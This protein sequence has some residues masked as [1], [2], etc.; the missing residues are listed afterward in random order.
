MPGVD[1]RVRSGAAGMM[2]AGLMSAGLMAAGMMGLGGCGLFGGKDQAPSLISVERDLQLQAYDRALQR[3]DY[4]ENEGRLTEPGRAQAKLLRAEIAIAAGHPQSALEHIEPTFEYPELLAAA[5][6]IQGKA[7]IRLE[8]YA[9]AAAALELAE[10]EYEN[11]Q[12][13]LAAADMKYFARGLDAY[14]QGN[15]AV[16]KADWSQIRDLRLRRSIEES[17]VMLSA[18]DDRQLRR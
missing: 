8:R 1:L 6:E 16:A 5:N 10:N 9:E 3:L 11:L 12:D 14:A 7:L 17:E 15:F 4:I 13:K 2:A 18:V